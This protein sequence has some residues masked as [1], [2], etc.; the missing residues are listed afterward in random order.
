[1]Y[2]IKSIEDLR[3]NWKMIINDKNNLSEKDIMSYHS[4]LE[5]FLIYGN[6]AKVSLKPYLND[7]DQNL[8]IFNGIKNHLIKKRFFIFDITIII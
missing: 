8:N 7:N 6:T 2:K 1:M 4:N 3:N 5:K